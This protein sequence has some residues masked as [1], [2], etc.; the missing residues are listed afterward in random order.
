MLRKMAGGMSRTD[1]EAACKKSAGSV[2]MTKHPLTPSKAGPGTMPANMPWNS[3]PALGQMGGAGPLKAS[4]EHNIKHAHGTSLGTGAV[5][6]DEP[7]KAAVDFKKSLG[8]VI[9]K[10]DREA[11]AEY[12]RRQNMTPDDEAE[13]WK[14]IEWAENVFAALHAVFET[15]SWSGYSL[16]NI[17]M[18]K[19]QGSAGPASMKTPNSPAWGPVE[20]F[21]FHTEV[22][23]RV[24]DS[25]K[26]MI[27]KNKLAK[28]LE[29]IRLA[30]DHSKMQSG[31]LTP[32]DVRMLELAI[33]WAQ[34]GPP[35]A[36]SRAG[37]PTADTGTSRRTKP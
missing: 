8:R 22:A 3:G 24:W 15:T 26:K 21:P 36:V 32:E 28:P 30:M 23:G 25:A 37:G 11:W 33:S 4:V 18:V 31:E 19:M 9:T 13:G 20:A 2:G 16:P 34:N 27:L 7:F 5:V 14:A 12:A 17:A 29:I 35:S 1:A 10:K 6:R